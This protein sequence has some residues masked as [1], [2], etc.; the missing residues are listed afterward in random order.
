MGYTNGWNSWSSQMVSNIPLKAGVQVL[1]V[2]FDHGEF[3]LGKLTFTYDAPLNYSQP[4][5]DA[6]ADQLVVFPQST[7]I[8]D[9]T[10]STDPGGGALNY[11]WTQVYGPSALQLSSVTASQTN[12]SGIVQ[13]VYL[14]RLEVDNGT[15]H[16]QDEVYIIS[17]ATN[18]LPPSVSIHS[19]AHQSQ[20]YSN[21]TISIAA[22]ASDINDYVDRVYFLANGQLLGSDSQAPFDWQWTPQ[23]TGTYDLSAIAVDGFGDSTTSQVIQVDI[24]S[25][26]SCEQSSWNGDFNY[27]FSPDANNP[28]ITFIPSIA[29]MGSPTCI[30]YYG[31]NPG[32]MPGYYVTP[33]VPFALNAS[34]GST[35]YFYY[36]YSYPGQGERNNSANMDSYVVGSCTDSTSSGPPPA[37]SG[38]N[39]TFSVD[40]SDYTGSFTTVNVNGD[41]NGWCGTCNPLTDMGSG[42][43][44]ATLPL[45]VDSI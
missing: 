2:Y 39:I 41:F 26:P 1:R 14:M 30:L 4:V 32:S 3:N 20:H 34:F 27:R 23:T 36:T 33:N 21:S 12:A 29:G 42:I 7:V 24:V 35:V 11:Q 13:G 8:L 43:W 38:G 19:P 6:G 45:T 40:M 9:G 28:T 18:N 10:A 31:T 22:N 15:Y 16:D 37:S 25:A 17:S 44:E 5:A